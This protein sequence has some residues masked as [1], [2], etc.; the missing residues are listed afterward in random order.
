M[1]YLAQIIGEYASFFDQYGNYVM[2][3]VFLLILLIDWKISKSNISN[4]KKKIVRP[5]LTILAIFLGIFIY[6]INFSFK[7]MVETLSTVDKAIGTEMIHFE[8]LNITTNEIEALNDYKEKIVLLNFWGTYCPPCI[9]EFPD[10]KKLEI[11]YPEDLVVIAISDEDPT[12]I[13]QFVSKV[14]SPST[15]G[16]QKNYQWINPEKFLPMTIIIDQGKIQNRFFGSRT[17]E[18]FIEIIRTS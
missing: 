8:Y 17:Y 4:H 11:Q 1:E 3:P 13:K 18:E 7:P 5:I 14:T 2:I 12:I 15:V 6:L 16:S 9:K 10:L